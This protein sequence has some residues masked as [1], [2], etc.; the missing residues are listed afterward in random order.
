[1]YWNLIEACKCWAFEAM[2]FRAC[3]YYFVINAGFEAKILLISLEKR[4][5]YE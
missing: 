4:N 1:M 5:L 3:E 2:P